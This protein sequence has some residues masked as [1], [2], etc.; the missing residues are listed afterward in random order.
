MTLRHNYRYFI[1]TQPYP[2][3]A[4]STGKVCLD[5]GLKHVDVF[6]KSI[7]LV[8]S[9]SHNLNLVTLVLSLT[10]FVFFYKRL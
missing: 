6:F 5:D 4:G 7:R 10:M 8:T 3:A 9:I 1:I 2:V